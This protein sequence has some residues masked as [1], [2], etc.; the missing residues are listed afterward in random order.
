MA[1]LAGTAKINLSYQAPGGGTVQVPQKTAALSYGESSIGTGAV[2]SGTEVNDTV[3]IPFGTINIASAL[4]VIN[5][6]TQVLGL[7]V[8]G[9]S[10]TVPVAAN[11]GVVL[12]QAALTSATLVA[13]ATGPTVSTEY[14]DYWVMGDAV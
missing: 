7:K 1:N 4:Y 13:T 3:S 11:G 9:G 6:S 12:V 8:N 2:P 14:F 10:D 5:Y